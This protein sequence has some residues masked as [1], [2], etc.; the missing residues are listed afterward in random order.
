MK[1][2]QI[3]KV[4]YDEIVEYCKF[5]NISSIN[6]EIISFIKKGFNLVKYGSTPFFSKQFKAIDE[7]SNQ[8]DDVI[9]KETKE[10]VE[11][12]NEIVKPTEDVVIN[13]KKKGIT[14][15]KK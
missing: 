2:V 9:E 7:I 6:N 10:V 8:K 3:P 4:L 5:N 14:I 11:V 1:K 12:K 15:V 13:T